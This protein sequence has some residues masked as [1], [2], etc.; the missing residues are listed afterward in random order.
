MANLFD[1]SV[2]LNLLFNEFRVLIFKI[3]LIF[4]LNDQLNILNIRKLCELDNQT[5]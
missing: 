1:G 3:A 4:P 5:L 2:K